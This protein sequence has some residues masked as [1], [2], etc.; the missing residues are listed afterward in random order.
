LVLYSPTYSP[1]AILSRLLQLLTPSPS[2]VAGNKIEERGQGQQEVEPSLSLIEIAAH[3][4]LAIGL[5]K[6][7]VEEVERITA[8]SVATGSEGGG[9]VGGIVRDEQAEQGSG[10]VRWY[11]D[12]I[13]AWPVEAM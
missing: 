10:G 6:E 9:A 8:A 1:T 2:S 4:G 11:R 13:S 5:V 3:E 7:L 12:L